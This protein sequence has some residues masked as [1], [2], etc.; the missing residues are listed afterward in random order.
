MNGV[1]RLSINWNGPPGWI[2]IGY[3]FCCCFFFCCFGFIQTYSFTVEWLCL[4]YPFRLMQCSECGSM[5]YMLNG[6]DVIVQT[7]WHCIVLFNQL[8]NLHIK[9]TRSCL[10]S[11]SQAFDGIDIFS[12]I[13]GLTCRIRFTSIREK[14]LNERWWNVIMRRIYTSI[15]NIRARN[16]Q[17]MEDMMIRCHKFTKIQ[18]KFFEK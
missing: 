18:S 1:K 7:A 9:H 12:Y 5:L 2:D 11:Y 16:N 15:M 13:F 8:R 3:S 10:L 4:L 17:D 14:L 6:Y